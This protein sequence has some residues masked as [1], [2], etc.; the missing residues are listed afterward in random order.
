MHK[1]L[2]SLE[3]ASNLTFEEALKYAG[4][5]PGGDL[6][7]SKEALKDYERIYK[8]ENGENLPEI[9]VR[10]RLMEMRE[11]IAAK[12]EQ[13]AAIKD[14]LKND[15]LNRS[16]KLAEE[17]TWDRKVLETGFLPKGEFCKEKRTVGKMTQEIL[18]TD[19]ELVG[20]LG[21]YDADK[22]VI[23]PMKI[24]DK[25]L[26]NLGLEQFVPEK[27][28]GELDKLA[29]RAEAI[30]EIKEMLGNLDPLKLSGRAGRGRDF[31]RL[32][33]ITE[34][35]YAGYV[36]GTQV[37]HGKKLLFRTDLHGAAR[38]LDIID[39]GYGEEMSELVGINHRVILA[40][41]LLEHGKKEIYR[42][43]QEYQEMQKKGEVGVMKKPEMMH[44]YERIIAELLE[45][46]GDVINGEKLKIQNQLE[47]S[48]DLI[49]K[50]IRPARVKTVKG[51]KVETPAQEYETINI[52]AKLARLS[53]IHDSITKR[54]KEIRSIQT[55]LLADEQVLKDKIDN[56]EAPFVD[57]IKT[58]EGMHEQFKVYSDKGMTAQ[59]GFSVAKNLDVMIVTAFKNSFP[60][61]KA[62][63]EPYASFKAKMLEQTQK[64]I[65]LLVD[66]AASINSEVE[67]KLDKQDAAEVAKE[68]TKIYLIAKIVG[69][70][71]D[72]QGFYAGNLSGEDREMGEKALKEIE[73]IK[74]KFGKREV[75]PQ[76][77]VKDFADQYDE[78][79]HLVNSLRKKT[80][81]INQKNREIEEITEQ[82]EEMKG[83][84]VLELQ[85]IKKK[86]VGLEKE[87]R[88]LKNAAKERFRN[89]DF[90]K[91]IRGLEIN[92]SEGQEAGKP[93]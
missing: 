71:K 37:N 32:F 62:Y 53:A 51:Q 41:G 1:I 12:V 54:I 50:R 82:L 17:R 86:M 89:F 60:E 64:T 77:E 81:E 2:P 30:S 29:R 8:D 16:A 22:A 13:V 7:R 11:R 58:V 59:E 70:H 68:F 19:Y 78:F 21:N 27:K 9:L 72:L 38:R 87:K 90:A 3:D 25:L 42:A 23:D 66:K 5:L 83:A 26:E 34:G 92:S 63:L 79:Y 65:A 91:M 28:A 93:N 56:M 57:F 36:L 55:Y 15:G 76:V 69:L 39:Q 73:E 88:R 24:T 85:D 52:E 80:V 35:E 61:G 44:K 40:K 20:G 43:F 48:A 18:S 74:A 75:A 46:L 33:T 47:Q 45:S 10:L 4:A 14:K 31:L 6:P 49:E 67:A 84:D